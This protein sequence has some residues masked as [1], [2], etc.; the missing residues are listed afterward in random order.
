CASF[1]L[2]ASCATSSKPSPPDEGEL[3]ASGARL[4]SEGR[5]DEAER[6]W[7]AIADPGIRSRY[8][9]FLEAYSAFDA[10]ASGAET[11]LSTSGPEA[12]LTAVKESGYL[13][14]PPMPIDLSSADPRGAKERLDRVGTAASRALVAQATEAERAADA[15]LDSARSGSGKDPSASA[16]KA[17]GGFE[18]AGR[19]YRGASGFMP[20]AEQNAKE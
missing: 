3:I 6:A 18:E 11:T 5:L 17:L 13:P 7:S 19:L 16:G 12:A 4:F 20:Q 14:A 1:I 15:D 8:L 9:S 10:A 2:A